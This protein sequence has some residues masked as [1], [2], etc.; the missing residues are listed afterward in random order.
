ML[1]SLEITNDTLAQKACNTLIQWYKAGY[2]KQQVDLVYNSLHIRYEYKL[3]MDYDCRSI[4]GDDPYDLQDRFYGN[5]T[6]FVPGQYHGT[7]VAGVIGATRSNGIGSNGITN[8]VELMII[9]AIPAG[10]ERDKDVANAIYYAVDN[11]ANIINMSFGKPYSPNQSHVEEAIRYA[12]ENG[13]LLISGSGNDGS[14]KDENPRYPNKFYLNEG[15]C[16][17]W[18]NVG[19]TSWRVDSTFIAPFSNYGDKSVDIMAP[20]TDILSLFPNNE[21]FITEGTSISAPMV[22]GVAALVWSYFPELK[23]QEVKDILIESVEYFGDC[24]VLLPGSSDKKVLFKE[25]SKTGGI[26]NA[27]KAILLADKLLD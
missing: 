20:G 4:I 14:N 7:S 10:D 5:Q 27:Y 13:V 22:S 3:N 6:V 24:V 23:A 19:S 25:L 8:N 16:S 11:G 1:E 18:I 15:E 26:V 2:S 21:T 12:E 17:S 9:R